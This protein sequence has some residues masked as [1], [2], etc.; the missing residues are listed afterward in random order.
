MPLY[1][2]VR[3]GDTVRIGDTVI[4]V[5]HKS[6]QT[7]RWSIDTDLPVVHSKGLKPSPTTA[8]SPPQPA[9]DKPEPGPRRPQLYRSA[10]IAE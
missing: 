6:G 5:E 7:M 2:E 4:R 9:P 10:A 8:E 1:R 3:P